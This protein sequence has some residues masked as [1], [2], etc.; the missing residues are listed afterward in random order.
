MKPDKFILLSLLP[1]ILAFTL[2]SSA[3]ATH[4]EESTGDSTIVCREGYTLVF[5]FVNHE[6]VCTSPST[7]ASWVKL[8]LAEIIQN[9]T[10]ETVETTEISTPEPVETPI[11][12][13]T[14]PPVIDIAKCREG[15]T[16]VFRF[17]HHD[18]FCTSPSTAASWVKLGLAEI[19]QEFTEPVEK[20]SYPT[21]EIEDENKENAPTKSDVKTSVSDKKNIILPSYP[22]QPSI[23]PELLAT[24]DY[25]YPPTVHKINERIWV[26]VGYDSANSV[27]IEGEKG[28]IIIDTLSTYESAQNVM[29]EFRKITDKPVKTIIYTS[30]NLEQVGGTKAF[31]EE[32]DDDVEIIA[33]ENNLNFYTNQNI[34]LG[35]ITALRNQYATGSFLPKEGPD[36]NNQ[37][38]S[39][40]TS[41]I[42]YVPPTDTFLDKFNLDISGVKMNLVHIGD[43]SS[44]Q[45]YVWLPDDESILIGDNI[46]GIFPN[47]YTLRGTGYHDPMNYVS[48]LDE[49]ILQKPQSLILSHV[50]PVI[51]KENVKDNLVSTRDATQYIYD[52]TIRGINND[53]TADELS[54]MIK[55]PT[56]LENHPWLTYQKSQ[57]S[58]NVKQIYYGTLGWFEGDPAFLQPVSLDKR[59]SKIIEG[60]GGPENALLDVRKAI[61]NGEYEWASELVTYVLHVE[62]ENTEAKL[63]KANTLRVFGQRTTSFDARHL[64]LTNAL[65]LEGKITINP[66]AIS[67]ANSEQLADIPIEKL[68][69]VLPTK[70]K[71]D[72]A[73]NIY[74]VMSIYYP[75]I[76]KTFL[77]HFR[78]NILVISESSDESPKY[79]LILDTK[80]HK[81]ILSGDLKLI[82]AINSKQV[83]FEGDM[84][85]ILYLMGLV[86]ED[87]DGIPIKF[88]T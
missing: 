63:L 71:S 44:D 73:D 74:A 18:T 64:A 3:F 88:E 26:A 75:D 57:I 68:L 80:T 86:Q 54:N 81:S 85:N 2:Q 11:P 47:T 69:Y 32:G 52:Q 87:S 84:N 49:I 19:I 30:G 40:I 41:T 8:G 35:Q 34:M 13:K 20:Q 53:Y 38:I 83:E 46:Y 17:T 7:A 25:R 37:D 5:R 43:K 29:D 48:A 39:E 65:E 82:D 61:E 21:T 59:S 67:Q 50:K 16:L 22:D 76:D 78:H 27:M 10:T 77:L 56:S 72:K 4:S 45:I 23:N 62:P 70:L 66:N 36:K 51:G 33:Y 12:K 31:L 79:R 6:Y 60:F 24:N 1:I 15:Y 9:A 14:L 42:A 28:I 55:L 58:W